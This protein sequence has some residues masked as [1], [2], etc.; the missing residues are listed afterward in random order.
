MHLHRNLNCLVLFAVFSAMAVLPLQAKD[1]ANSSPQIESQQLEIL[2]NDSPPAEKA[3]ACKKLAIHGSSA[4]VPELAKLLPNPQLSSWA[5]IALEAIPGTE[6]DEAL[7]K[8]TESLEGKLLVGTINSIGVRRDARAVDALTARLSDKDHDVAAAAAVA[9]GHIGTTAAADQLRR[10]LGDVPDKVR[11]AVAEGCILCA[12]RFLAEGNSDTA[13]EIYDEVRNAD[14]PHQRMLEA[15]RGAILARKND[16]IPMLVEQFRSPDKRMFQLALGTAREFPGGEVDQALAAELDRA[17]PQRAAL[18]VLAMADREETVV[19]PAVVKA[20][21]KGPKQVRLAAISALG[22]VG[23]ASCLSELI[24]IG[25]EEDAELSQAAR[26]ALGVLPGKET[27][28]KIAAMLPDAE[29]R[30]YPL[31][32]DVVG[33]RRIDAGPQLLD[34]LKHS[35]PAVRAAA[36]G[37]LG[38]TIRFAQL[39][40]LISQAIN[41]EHAEDAPAARLALKTA[42]VRMP[43]REACAA[44]LA[45]A[46]KNSASVPT[47]TMLLQILGD[48]GGTNALQTIGLA[49][50]SDDPQLQDVSSQLLGKWMTADAAPVLLDLSKTA[51][52]EKYQIRALRGY[53]RIARQFKLPIRKRV[54]MC[55]KAL[56]AADRPAEQEMVMDVLQRYP[57]RQ[58]L[59]LAIESAQTPAVKKKATQV[60]LAIA[61]KLGSRG[62][63]LRE[64]LTQAGLEKV[65]LEIVKAEYGTN[66]VQQDVT[67]VLQQTASDSPLIVLSSSNYNDS[68][69]DPAPGAVKQLKVRYRI[70]GK[71]GEA[72]FSENDLI[73]LPL[74]E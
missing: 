39:P 62:E 70:N 26:D 17:A 60:T 3:I 41:P 19:L 24:A 11:S 69:G 5:R 46:I 58:T 45:E 7:R 34:A 2:R 53:I 15:T 72:T 66:K 42:C 56:E 13:I 49:A 68:F 74:P 18:I 9:F 61:Q 28:A 22:Q 35:D 1:G 6:A 48:V 50:R 65:D 29:G 27:D 12:E 16:G 44:K 73:L 52:A 43:D 25:L 33:K 54:E 23:D 37:A 20:A 36:L 63:E 59:K 4:A 51:P 64:L 55:R 40:M 14:V 47:R 10:S 31:L 71:E 57:H 67:K 32:I 21:E 8:A 30:A 38:E